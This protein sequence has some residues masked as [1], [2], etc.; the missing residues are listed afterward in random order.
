MDISGTWK[1]FGK[2]A[3]QSKPIVIDKDEITYYSAVGNSEP[4]KNT[5]KFEMLRTYYM[6]DLECYDLKIEGDEYKSMDYMVH[7]E[8]INGRPVVIFSI[9]GMEY[10]GRGRVVMASFIREEDADLVDENYV[11]EAVK[12]W[13][14]RPTVSPTMIKNPTQGGFTMA[15][16]NRMIPLGNQTNDE[17]SS[18]VKLWN[19]GCGLKGNSGKFCPE[20]GKSRPY[21]P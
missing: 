7:E 20:C 5:K 12:F 1:A 3:V 21:L 4:V 9:M 15:M 18:E 14:R 6:R 10:D 11:S 16:G 2:R 19:C 8:T 13:N 17:Q